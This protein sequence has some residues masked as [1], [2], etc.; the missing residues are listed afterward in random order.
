MAKFGQVTHYSTII[1]AAATITMSVAGYW[2]FEEK[3]LSN[4]LVSRARTHTV[5][6]LVAS[7]SHLSVLQNNFPDTDTMVNI[8][9]GLFGL[10]M[11]TTLPLECFVCREV[12]ET[13]FFAG[14][15]DRNRHLIFTSSLVVSAM[16]VSLVT[17]DLGIVLEVTGGLSATALAFIFPAVCYLKLTANAKVH[18][19][20][21]GNM[22]SVASHDPEEEEEDREVDDVELPLRPGANVRLRP[23]E[24]HRK[25]YQSTRILSILCSAFGIVVLVISG[26]YPRPTI[27]R[28]P[29]LLHA[30]TTSTPFSRAVHSMDRSVRLCK[31]SNWRSTP[32]LN[33]AIETEQSKPLFSIQ[34]KS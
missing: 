5:F 2:S 28:L 8:A 4:V 32:M 19:A 30:H 11:L 29:S 34:S 23:I 6:L 31:R 24:H 25:W 33:T 17:C 10:N 18:T 16:V 3:T 26:T 13:Y 12:L 21:L 1:A 15:F 7:H 20:T 9:R 14:E 27:P 22:T